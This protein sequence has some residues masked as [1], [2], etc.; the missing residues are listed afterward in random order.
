L[1]STLLAVLRPASTPPSH[2]SSSRHTGILKQT[3]GGGEQQPAR[4]EGER[5]RARSRTHGP[6]ELSGFSFLALEALNRL[7]AGFVL[8]GRQIAALV[9]REVRE[10]G[11]EARAVA[12]HEHVVEGHLIR[13]E[14]RAHQK[15]QHPILLEGY[16]G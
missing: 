12:A 11:G 7:M 5:V 10:L 4:G 14:R 1:R 3:L 6:Q 8:P 15:P 16:R 2:S 13:S 9:A